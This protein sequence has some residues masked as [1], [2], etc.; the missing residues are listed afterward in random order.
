MLVTDDVSHF[1]ISWLKTDPVPKAS[2]MFVTLDVFQF[3]IG[4]LNALFPLNIRYMF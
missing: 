2:P 4:W 1:E 3:P